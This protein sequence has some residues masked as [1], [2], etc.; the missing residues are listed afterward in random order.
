MYAADLQRQRAAM[1]EAQRKAEQAAAQVAPP[2]GRV[3]SPLLPTAP[4]PEVPTNI[5]LRTEYDV[6]YI[7]PDKIPRK[8]LI[9]DYDAILADLKAGLPVE[10]CEL[11]T[12][13]KVVTGR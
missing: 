12:M 7:N 8:Y 11:V 5:P 6:R 2:P 4:L 9:P 3:V 10:G 13:K 1:L